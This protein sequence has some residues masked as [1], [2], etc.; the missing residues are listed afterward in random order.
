MNFF[1]VMQGYLSAEHNLVLQRQRVRDSLCRVD[2]SGT[3]Q[4]KRKALKR[5]VYSV[6]TA[7]GMVML[8]ASLKG[9]IYH[10]LKNLYL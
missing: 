10:S 5:R 7:F 3:L 1:Q 6:P 2:L 9:Q 4:R 8:T